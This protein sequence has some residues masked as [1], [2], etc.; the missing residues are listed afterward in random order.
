MDVSEDRLAVIAAREVD[1]AETD[2]PRLEAALADGSLELTSKAVA[3]AEADA[4][5]I[6]VPTPVDGDHQPDLTA[7]RGACAAVVEQARPGQTILL[8]STTYS[9]RHGNCSPSRSRPEACRPVSTFSWPS[10]PSA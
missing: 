2:R 10:A 6:C 5:I 3:I 7:L 4:V 1:L 9:A 8:T